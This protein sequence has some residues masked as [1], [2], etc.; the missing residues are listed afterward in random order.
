MSGVKP[1]FKSLPLMQRAVAATTVARQAGVY[2][3]FGSCLISKL[4]RYSQ[5]NVHTITSVESPLDQ[6]VAMRVEVSI[7]GYG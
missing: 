3:E 4:A 5:A 1:Q 6:N 2:Y 7:S